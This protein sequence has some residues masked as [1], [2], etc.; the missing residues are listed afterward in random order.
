[1]KE[2]EATISEIRKC[3]YHCPLPRKAPRV[4]LRGRSGKVKH[5]SEEEIFIYQLKKIGKELN[6]HELY[7]L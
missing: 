4:T 7:S 3:L 2:P 6:F 1:M 5:F